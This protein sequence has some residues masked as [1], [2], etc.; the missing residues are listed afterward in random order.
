MARPWTQV[1][2]SNTGYGLLAVVVERLM[3]APYPA[4]LRDLV[5]APLEIEG[6]FGEEPPRPPAHIAGDWGQHLGTP[7]EPYNT[8]FW[9]SLALPYGGLVTTAA[10]ANRLVQ[11]FAGR[12]NGFLPPDL[13]AEA[14]RDQTSGL[15]GRLLGLWE[16]E[17]APW[18]LGAELR[19]GKTPHA[20]ATEASPGS[21]G[22]LGASG[23]QAWYDPSA[24]VAWGIF[25]PRLFF[26]WW[27]HMPAIG[28]AILRYLLYNMG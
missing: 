12:P 5:L 23:C 7:L 1:N 10:G 2:Y 20:V 22:H 13:L 9:R 3:G 19:G 14:R 27:E 21:F 17:R 6:S 26:E 16:W 4:A 24:G 18:G 8:P 15:P 28:A 11:A 25:G